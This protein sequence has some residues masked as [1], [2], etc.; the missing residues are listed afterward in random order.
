LTTRLFN[1]AM[2][3]YVADGGQIHQVEEK[4]PEYVSC[5]FHYD[6]RLP[7]S[8][9][10]VYVETVLVRKEDIEDCVIWVVNVHDV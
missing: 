6:L 1:E 4:R 3:R 7:V 5:R 8:G 9:R 2:V 10:R